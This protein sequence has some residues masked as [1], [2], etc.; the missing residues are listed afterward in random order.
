M[1]NLE[2]PLDFVD[3]DEDVVYKKEF[4]NFTPFMPGDFR[5]ESWAVKEVKDYTC[6][7]KNN[8]TIECVL[9]ANLVFT[10][11]NLTT[12]LVGRLRWTLRALLV[13]YVDNPSKFSDV[14]E[15]FKLRVRIDDN[16]L[17]MSLIDFIFGTLDA[18]KIV[19]N[20]KR[21]SRIAWGS[22]YK[23]TVQYHN[24]P[25]IWPLA[26]KCASLQLFHNQLS[27]RYKGEGQ[28]KKEQSKGKDI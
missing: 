21:V 15:G 4:V 22:P 27:E 18:Y 11:P 9:K 2:L 19:G 16:V 12:A 8:N 28:T 1:F 6:I 25:K 20:G 14:D 23:I 13:A 26:L 24:E 7:E 5:G 17:E 3:L 10:R